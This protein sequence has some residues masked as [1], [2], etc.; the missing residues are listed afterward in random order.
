MTPKYRDLSL[1]TKLAEMLQ[2]V[3][4]ISWGEHAHQFHFG[5]PFLEKLSRANSDKLNSLLRAL[6]IT[7]TAIAKGAHSS[8]TTV[9]RAL[10]PDEDVRPYNRKKIL[11]IVERIINAELRRFPVREYDIF[12][13]HI[14]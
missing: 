9:G 10:N 6:E 8:A 5:T 3:G 11:R 7:H 12:S 14:D 1:P 2:S 4:S 13:E